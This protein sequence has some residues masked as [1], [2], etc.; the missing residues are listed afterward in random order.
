MK[1]VILSTGLALALIASAGAV[2]ITATPSTHKVYVDGEKAN[3]AAYEINGNNFFKLRD[4][5][6][7]LNGTDAQFEVTWNGAENR[8]DLTDG[9]AYTTV[10]GELETIPAGTQTANLS[11]AWV[12]QDGRPASLT[13]FEI[14]GNNYYKLRDVADAFDFN[15]TWD[16]ENQRVDIITTESYDDGEEPDE[17]APPE[18]NS[19][20]KQAY[21]TLDYDEVNPDYQEQVDAFPGT[22]VTVSVELK[23]YDIKNNRYIYPADLELRVVAN[24]PN[25]SN[26]YDDS[27]PETTAV[28]KI[29]TDSNGH[30][31]LTVDI[32]ESVYEKMKDNKDEFYSISGPD[33]YGHDFIYDGKTYSAGGDLTYYECEAGSVQIVCIE[34]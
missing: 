18:Y 22:P 32:P 6:A 29:K 28:K 8:I 19:E 25:P 34:R 12:Y 5:A 30:V 4:I 23:F 11:M 24:R 16:G 3:V 13:G 31:T 27:F 33:L 14:N 20:Y 21:E 9:K 2:S 26:D 1:K 17:P 7:I 10:G 15:V